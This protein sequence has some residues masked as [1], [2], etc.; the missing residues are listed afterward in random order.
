MKENVAFDPGRV[1]FFGAEGV[2][3]AADFLANLV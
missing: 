1:R 2:V 3:Q